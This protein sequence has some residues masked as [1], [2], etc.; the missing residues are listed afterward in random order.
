MKIV[1]DRK[2][3]GFS[4]AALKP[5]EALASLH[6]LYKCVDHIPRDDDL[7]PECRKIP[8]QQINDA[9]SALIAILQDRAKAINLKIAS[10]YTM[11]EFI[12]PIL[13]TV[14]NL[15]I[16]YRSTLSESS[17]D[18]S[19]LSLVCERVLLGMNAQGPVD[20]SILFDLID[21][22]LSEA[23]K[24]DLDTGVVQCLLQ[25][26]ASQ[27]FLVNVLIDLE[28]N[29]ESRKRKFEETFDVVSAIP[30]FGITSTGSEWV[31]STIFIDSSGQTCVVLSNTIQLDLA[32][33]DLTT[34][35]NLVSR[36]VNIVLNQI[37]KVKE[38][39]ELQET[40][41]S[42]FKKRVATNVDKI[43]SIV[44]MQSTIVNEIEAIGIEGE[45]SVDVKC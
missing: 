25:Q 18:R 41:E 17:S 36:I 15:A 27:E 34:V 37:E 33:P 35:S 22:V 6:S 2:S 1:V 16:D 44:S 30:T 24:K 11:R 28:L 3:Q 29:G 45:D 5:M 31:F 10:E 38:S 42:F 21:L 8:Q 40:A 12:S 19:K 23:K 7:F 43:N 9:S 32:R 14:V 4:T 13:V 26:R 39:K 20:Y